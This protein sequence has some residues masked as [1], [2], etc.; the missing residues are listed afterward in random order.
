MPINFGSIGP[1]TCVGTFNQVP[2]L[3]KLKDK[4]GL[5]KNSKK[6]LFRLKVET[7]DK[8]YI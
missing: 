6:E 4:S 2:D 8:P 7:S 1:R 5:L 3:V